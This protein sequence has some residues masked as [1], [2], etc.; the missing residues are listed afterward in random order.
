MVDLDLSIDLWI[1]FA[2]NC[3]CLRE[4]YFDSDRPGCKGY[5]SFCW[6]DEKKEAA[7]DALFQIPTLEKV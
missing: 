6:D 4:I 1:E 2:K 3:T 5:D 7:L